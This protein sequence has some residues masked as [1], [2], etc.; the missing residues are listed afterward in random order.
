MKKRLRWDYAG[1]LF[2]GDE[3]VGR[4]DRGSE[5]EQVDIA[6]EVMTGGAGYEA[7]S[8]LIRRGG[9]G[10]VSGCCSPLRFGSFC[11]YVRLVE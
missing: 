3:V 2:P 7:D 6:V 1:E 10:V 9:R 8:D 4:G 11:G 5:D